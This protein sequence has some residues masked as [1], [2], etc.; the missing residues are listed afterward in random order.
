LVFKCEWKVG[1]ALGV[2]YRG[3]VDNSAAEKSTALGGAAGTGWR[4]A[5]C[6]LG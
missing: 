2:S 1:E 5:D 3:R 6:S 4:G